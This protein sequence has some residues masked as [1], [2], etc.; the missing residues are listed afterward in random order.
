MSAENY[1]ELTSGVILEITK[2]ML[3]ALGVEVDELFPDTEISH[4]AALSE[5]PGA[6]EDTASAGETSADNGAETPVE[7]LAGF[8][9]EKTVLQERI[10]RLQEELKQLFWYGTNTPEGREVARLEGDLNYDEARL[11]AL[12]EEIQ[13]VAGSE[14]EEVIRNARAEMKTMQESLEPIEKRVRDLEGP[15]L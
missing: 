10:D 7:A 11:A 9:S 12:T 6:E 3:A 1:A 5:H 4:G 13:E 2:R 8:E 15:P 14:R